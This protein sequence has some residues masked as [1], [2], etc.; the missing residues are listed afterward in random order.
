M[1]WFSEPYLTYLK[2]R[3]NIAASILQS[4][5]ILASAYESSQNSDGSA[6]IE[7]EK[8]LDSIDGKIQQF[9][10]NAQEF[11]S[12]LINSDAVKVILDVANELL[13]V[14]TEIIDVGNGIPALLATIGGI[15]FFKNLDWG[16]TAHTLFLYR[17][18]IFE[19]K[20]A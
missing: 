19:K 18:S 10:N 6:A 4:P 14:I 9:K 15:S 7:L 1:V 3:A 20:I 16:K 11:W 12:A 2:N 13:N 5:D 8:Y 17:W